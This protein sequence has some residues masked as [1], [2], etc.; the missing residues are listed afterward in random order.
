LPQSE[1]TVPST[2]PLQKLGPGGG[3]PQVPSVAPDALV[4]TP[5]QQSVASE[6]TSPFWMQNDDPILH[7]PPEQSLEQHSSPV[8]HGLPDVLHTVLS[9]WQTPPV[10]V[11]LQQLVPLVQ[12]LLSATH[13]AAA[14]RL[15]THETLQQS[16]LALHAPPAAMQ[17]VTVDVQVW[18][19]GS[20]RPVQQSVPAEHA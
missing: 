14:H 5:P 15:P 19:L 9:V 7:V 11:P 8:V 6:Q 13:T 3:A 20:H 17:L 1:Q 16:V 2:P 18:V 10:Q 12:G 4:Q